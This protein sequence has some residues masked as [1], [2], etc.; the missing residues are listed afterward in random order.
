MVRKLM[1]GERIMYAGAETPVNCV[2]AATIRGTFTLERLRFALSKIQAKHPLLRV[3][4]HEDSSG[5]P[6]FISRDDIPEIPVRIVERY[7]D[8]AWEVESK[9]AWKKKFDLKNGPLARIV[10][11][12][13][14]DVSELLLVCPHVICDGASFVTLMRELLMLLDDPDKEIGTY[15]S[16][17]SVQELIPEHLLSRKRHIL[18]AK[19]FSLL[20]KVVLS[21]VFMGR[22][23]RAG[24]DYMV[25]WRLTKKVSSAFAICCKAEETSMHAALC[26]L[27]L[28]AFQHVKGA[29]ARNKVM[30]PADIRRVI[31]EI[32]DD[33]MFAF[34]PVVELSMDTN[35]ALDFWAKAR[36]FKYALS[37]KVEKLDVYELLMMGEQFHSSTKRV[38]RFLKA[39]KGN[40]DFTLSNMGWLDI[41][42]DFASFD[43]EALYSPTVAFPWRNPNTIVISI[44]RGELD[45]SF[46]SSDNFLSYRDALAIKEKAMALLFEQVSMLV[47]KPA[48][49]YSPVKSEV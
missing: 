18:K 38:V 36:K 15:A 14:P 23:A 28:Q 27:F 6:Y 12:R 41:P 34:A 11:L 22:P 19:L 32:K 9:A 8:N 24:G 43:V 16:F 46:V 44:S 35:P 20:A 37:E 26:V 1:I 21:S 3:S 5:T 31:P 49:A 25:H 42:D 30:C 2:F 33:M 48:N 45:F 10:W 4:V 13:S 7:A 47:G 17:N 40:H 39:T 29:R